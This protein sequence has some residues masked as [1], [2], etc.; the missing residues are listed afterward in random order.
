M[1][2][3]GRE[4]LTFLPGE[5]ARR[6]WP[7]VR[8]TDD[9]LGAVAQLICR[10]HDIVEK[11]ESPA[12]ASSRSDF[13]DLGPRCIVCHHH[14]GPWNVL[15]TDD[16]PTGIIDWDFAGPAPMLFPSLLDQIRGLVTYD[17]SRP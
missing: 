6:L 10:F 7:P 3:L 4:V 17:P 14:L 15:F 9:G 8:R 2:T 5:P 11:F 16:R 13:S 12:G 1:D